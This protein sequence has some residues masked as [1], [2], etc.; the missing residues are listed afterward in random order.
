MFE[1]R[2]VLLVQADL[3]ILL[4]HLNRESILDMLNSQ[5]LPNTPKLTDEI[6]VVFIFRIFLQEVFESLLQNWLWPNCIGIR[7]TRYS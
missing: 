6:L 4:V 5:I 1:L 2:D 7:P 3:E